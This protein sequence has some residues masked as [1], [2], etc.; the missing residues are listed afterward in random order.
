MEMAEHRNIY[1]HYGRRGLDSTLGE[2]GIDQHLLGG[3]R[4][5]T[6]TV[7]FSRA[8]AFLKVNINDFKSDWGCSIVKGKKGPL[9]TQIFHI[10]NVK[11]FFLG[12]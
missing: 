7:S 12:L 3:G 10:W 4:K 5:K 6:D 1:K 11:S 9:N 2:R 8:L